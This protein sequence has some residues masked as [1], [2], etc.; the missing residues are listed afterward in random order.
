VDAPQ[1]VAKVKR[2]ARHEPPTVPLFVRVPVETMEAVESIPLPKQ[3]VIRE[4]VAAY[5]AAYRQAN[6]PVRRQP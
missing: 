2:R 1:V 6:R 4:A 3:T 5:A